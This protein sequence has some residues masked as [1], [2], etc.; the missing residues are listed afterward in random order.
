MK[1]TVNSTIDET[2]TS[3]RIV[4]TYTNGTYEG[5]GSSIKVAEFKYVHDT[6]YTGTEEFKVTLSVA[7]SPDVIITENTT[8][9]AKTGSL[10]PYVGI[11]GGL[12]L[13]AAAYVISKKTT[14]FYRA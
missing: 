6:T 14:K 5:T 11:I 13:I 8:T 4:T 7:G 10:L 12:A 3:A 1:D 2:G 9:N